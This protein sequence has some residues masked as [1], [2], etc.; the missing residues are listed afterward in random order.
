MP[1]LVAAIVPVLVAAIV[2]VLVAAIVPD[3]AKEVAEKATTNM[4]AKAMDLMFF[5]VLLLVIQTSGVIWS[6]LRSRLLSYFLRTDL[7]QITDSTY[8]SSRN[9]PTI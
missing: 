5:I 9:V 3:L 2:P 7:L 1:V 8:A 4:P 6:V